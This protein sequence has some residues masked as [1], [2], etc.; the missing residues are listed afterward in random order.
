MTMAFLDA[1]DAGQT[2]KITAAGKK[3]NVP[4]GWSPISQST[5]ADKLYIIESGEVSVR[6]DGKEIT[7]LTA[8]DVMG[9]KAI[10]GHTLRTASLVALTRL[11]VIHFTDESIRTLCEELPGFRAE[12]EKAA[13]THS[14]EPSGGS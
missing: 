2:K 1:F 3:L 8:G 11:E 12:L 6:K 13:E 5:G 10:L 9:E 14:G 4:E 7:R